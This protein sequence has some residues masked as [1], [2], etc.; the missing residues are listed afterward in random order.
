MNCDRPHLS[1]VGGTAHSGTK[2]ATTG[3]SNA[4]D[5]KIEA[6]ELLRSV[7]REI[8][9]GRRHVTDI[10]IVHTVPPSSD[11]MTT[12]ITYLS[13]RGIDAAQAYW[14]FGRLQNRMALVE[15][16]SSAPTEP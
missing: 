3:T 10:V 13:T 16:A 2:Q 8:E 14:L 5:D 1:V 9:D 15:N 12:D 4:G 11:G 6:V 7:A